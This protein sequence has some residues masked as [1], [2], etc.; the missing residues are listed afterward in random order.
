MSLAGQTQRVPVH[1]AAVSI[2]QA[3]ERVAV[4]GG[5]TAPGPCF[6]EW[7]HA[8]VCPHDRLLRHVAPVWV[9]PNK[10]ADT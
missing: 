8:L 10:D 4:T 3:P 1:T 7:V 6:V 2:E 5:R 9:D